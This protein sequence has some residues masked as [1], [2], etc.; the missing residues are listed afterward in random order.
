MS[1]FDIVKVGLSADLAASG[2]ATITYPTG[3]SKGFYSGTDGKHVLVAGGNVYNAPK[4]FTLTFNA[5][6]SSI[7][8]TWGAANAT[9]VAG[10]NI[11]LQLSRPGYDG[12]GVADVANVTKMVAAGVY[13]VDLGSPNVADADGI[14]ASQS[15]TTLVAALLNGAVGATLDVPRNVVGAWTGTSVITI[16]GLDEY[17][18]VVVENSASGTSHT[19]T[20]AFKKITSIIPTG[21]ITSATFG[22][23]DVLGLPVALPT[24]G[25]VLREMEDGTTASAG[26][27]VAAIIAKATATTGDV[28]GTYDPNSACDGSKGF[29]LLL[30]L[31]DPDNKG[32]SQYAG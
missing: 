18:A 21:S 25:R 17:G 13:R 28:R 22:T 2:T 4:D 14:C 27:P 12:L 5:N 30:A 11:T 7:T 19:G 20:K 26:T 1:S 3:R 8:L 24:L 15:V 9:L 6:A 10:T 23:G 16:T 32:V 31:T 29:T